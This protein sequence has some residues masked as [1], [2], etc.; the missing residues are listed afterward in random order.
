MPPAGPVA[1]GANVIDKLHDVFAASEPLEQPPSEL[2]LKG[3]V[4]TGVLNVR[5][6][7]PVLVRVMVWAAL[8]VPT[9][10]VA[11]T[12]LFGTRVTTGNGVT[13]VPVMEIVCVPALS[14]IVMEA[15][16]VPVA[17]GLKVIEIAQDELAGRVPLAAQ[18]LKE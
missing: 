3:A 15:V 17:V 4:A 11:K 2:R 10:W 16:R 13:P 9:F 8:V 14:V 5:V 7:V 18:P 1:V 6:A 12:R